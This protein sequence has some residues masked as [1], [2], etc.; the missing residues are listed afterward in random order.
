MHFRLRYELAGMSLG[1]NEGKVLNFPYGGDHRVVVR[2][3]EQVVD[4]GKTLL[5]E[6]LSEREVE[7][8]VHDAFARLSSGL[9]LDKAQGAFFRET[10]SELYDYMG[11]TIKILRWRCSIMDG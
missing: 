11:Q 4:G 9:P 6:G 5:C 8:S 10:L 1:L 2:V 7:I 3:F